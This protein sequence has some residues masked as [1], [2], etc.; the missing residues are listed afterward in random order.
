MVPGG[1]LRICSLQLEL[2]GQWD[3]MD[4]SVIIP[5][6]PE[7]ELDLL[8]VRHQ[9]PYSGILSGGPAPRPT[10]LVR[11][12]RSRVGHHSARPVRLGLLVNRG[13]LSLDKFTPSVWGSIIFATLRGLIV[14]V[15]TDN[16][17]AL[18][19]VKKQGVCIPLHSTWKS[20]SSSSGWNCGI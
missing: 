14:G 17:A 8:V 5:W 2:C 1:W 9:P 16:T 15:F 11:R 12:L 3:F 20:N 18:S 10:P 7:N 4:E 19:Y 13:A 6:S